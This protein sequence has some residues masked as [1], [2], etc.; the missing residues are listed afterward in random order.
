VAKELGDD[1]R[2]ETME[3]RAIVCIVGTGLATDG[4]LRSR[5][6]AALAEI[7]PEM[8]ALGGSATSVAAVV[9]ERVLADA[10]RGLHRR[11]FESEEAA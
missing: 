6:L 2:L 3:D 11:F 8:V 4:A 9:P 1:V 7:A 10:V 5:V